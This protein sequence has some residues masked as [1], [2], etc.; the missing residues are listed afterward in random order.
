MIA[1]RYRK[2][3]FGRREGGAR[4]SAYVTVTVP[5]LNALRMEGSG[6]VEASGIAAGAFDINQEGSGDLEISGKCD[7]LTLDHEGSGDIDAR[8]LSCARAVL[9]LEGSG[10]VEINV[11]ETL[12]L[13]HAGSGDLDVWGSPRLSKFR[14][15]G[16]GK[17]EVHE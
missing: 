3:G 5:S 1:E 13:N 16:S 2:S 12:E 6:D 15:S 4:R 8:Q 9:D 17:F 14:F 10:D 11:S 7:N